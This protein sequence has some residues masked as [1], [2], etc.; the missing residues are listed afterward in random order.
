VKAPADGAT[1]YLPKN[2]LP[3]KYGTGTKIPP[4][5]MSQLLDPMGPRA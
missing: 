5:V 3:M 4:T 2:K 1:L